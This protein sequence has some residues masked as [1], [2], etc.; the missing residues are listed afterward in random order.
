MR[1]DEVKILYPNIKKIKKIF[2]WSPKTSLS[3]GINKTIKFYEN[4]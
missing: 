1:K 3:I 2:N 4:Q